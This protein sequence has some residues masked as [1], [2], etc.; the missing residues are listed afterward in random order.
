MA[1][2]AS[3][4]IDFVASNPIPTVLLVLLLL[5]VFG[6]YLFFRKTVQEFKRGFKGS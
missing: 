6:V 4:L 2:L 1:D 3:N 5:F